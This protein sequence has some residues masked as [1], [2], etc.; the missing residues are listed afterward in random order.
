[1]HSG[2]PALFVRITFWINKF[3][4]VLNLPQQEE[5]HLHIRSVGLSGVNKMNLKSMIL[6]LK[7]QQELVDNL[8]GYKVTAPNDFEWMSK[9]RMSW[10]KTV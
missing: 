6:F 4:K 9:L 8:I 10:K 5:A 7:H 1:M 2:L 3:I